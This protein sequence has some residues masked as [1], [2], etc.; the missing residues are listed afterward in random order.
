[1][2]WPTTAEARHPYPAVFF[3]QQ[4][5]HHHDHQD[6]LQPH[7][8]HPWRQPAYGP[9]DP[10]PMDD[11]DDPFN[12]QPLDIEPVELDPPRRHD[13]D[14]EEQPRGQKRKT[15]ADPESSNSQ[16]PKRQTLEEDPPPPKVNLGQCKYTPTN[17]LR[18]CAKGGKS[19]FGSKENPRST[20]YGFI[21][22]RSN[23]QACFEQKVQALK[24][25]KD[26]Y[27]HLN[28]PQY[29]DDPKHP[30]RRLYAFLFNQRKFYR[31]FQKGVK[32]PLTQERI[33]L[34]HNTL[35]A[36]HWLA[37][38][39]GEEAWPERIQQLHEFHK[40][41]GHTCVK[42]V[43]ANHPLINFVASIRKAYKHYEEKKE[44]ER[45]KAAGELDSD[46]DGPFVGTY[47]PRT[48]KKAMVGRMAPPVHTNKAALF[49]GGSSTEQNNVDAANDTQQQ[50]RGEK[51]IAAV[52][53]NE[54]ATTEPA[55]E[56]ETEKEPAKK[57]Y[58]VKP[59][60]HGPKSSGV[61]KIPV[62]YTPDKHAVLEALECPFMDFFCDHPDSKLKKVKMADSRWYQSAEQLRAVRQ[63]EPDNQFLTYVT[64][65]RQ[66]SRL[67][68][69][70]FRNREAYEHLLKM[71]PHILDRAKELPDDAPRSHKLL[72]KLFVQL[73]QVDMG[74][75][76]D[77]AICKRILDEQKRAHEDKLRKE[78]EEEARKQS[79]E[80][81]LEL[82]KEKE[83]AAKEKLR[84]AE[85]TL[86]EAQRV[87]D[88]AREEADAAESERLRIQGMITESPLGK[89]AIVRPRGGKRESGRA[90]I[91]RMTQQNVR[92]VGAMTFYS[93]KFVESGNVEHFVDGAFIER[94][95]QK[96]PA[97]KPA[98]VTATAKAHGA[99]VPP[100][101]PPKHKEASPA[102]NKAEVSPHTALLVAAAQKRA[103]LNARLSAGSSM[104]KGKAE[105]GKSI[106]SPSQSRPKRKTPPQENTKENHAEVP[107]EVLLIRNKKE[108]SWGMTLGRSQSGRAR[109][110][111]FTE[112]PASRHDNILAEDEI[113]KV[114]SKDAH[115]FREVVEE[116]QACRR[117]SLKLNIMRKERPLPS[118]P[119]TM[120]TRGRAKR[121][122]AEKL[123]QLRR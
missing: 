51:E 6:P 24:Q 71:K 17:N 93:I 8:L 113:V 123:L 27:G 86:K 47:Q 59:T 92:G 90:K 36:D 23:A 38:K 43:D 74:L 19:T 4:E 69:W 58:M 65:Y 79:P 81:K 25:Y 42:A 87:V 84:A 101:L 57:I 40:K 102:T 9:L 105:K 109:I 15:L 12:A 64:N 1:M 68:A 116:I 98:P 91:L 77:P 106:S 35:G 33:D 34:L 54:G 112:G 22:G 50:S 122:V 67:E 100:P 121:M 72:R 78:R 118:P 44:Y 46:D 66:L 32:V 60:G 20:S 39:E 95:D 75:E 63:K 41:Y 70:V 31:L 88:E 104:A 119:D 29:T 28:L 117:L 61:S 56:G 21:D 85:E 55:T 10:H 52:S 108:K 18:T 37:P 97:P 120:T 80:Y 48:K 73:L 26:Q 13:S 115:T 114:N 14:E 7:P 96:R 30:H 111:G 82:A 110:E 83:N 89:D 3:P 76:M 5:Q 45:K 94:L 53:E 16:L 2:D 103:P 11:D 99:Q 49:G 107:V 62:F